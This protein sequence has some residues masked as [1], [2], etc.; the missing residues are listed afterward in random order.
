[1]LHDCYSSFINVEQPSGIEINLR[2]FH[3]ED[4]SKNLSTFSLVNR[5]IRAADK[6]WGVRTDNSL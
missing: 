5:S 2:H 3:F 4:I 1:M 6:F